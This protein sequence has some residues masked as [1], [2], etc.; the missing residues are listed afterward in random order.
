M[1]GKKS[2]YKE[3]WCR[4]RIKLLF[5][6]SKPIAFL[7]FSFT[8]PSSL[9]KLP[10]T[11]WNHHIDVRTPRSLLLTRMA[12][13]SPAWPSSLKLGMNLVAAHY[14][15]SFHTVHIRVLPYLEFKVLIGYWSLFPAILAITRT[16]LHWLDLEQVEIR[17]ALFIKQETEWTE[18]FCTF[19]RIPSI[20]D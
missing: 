19:L 4:A 5:C 9:F 7:P 20:L 10:M 6:K 15:T 3:T 8:S 16:Y 2:G 18:W 17:K 14:A 1:T 11:L 12:A 13:D